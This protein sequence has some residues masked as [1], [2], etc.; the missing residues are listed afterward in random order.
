LWWHKLGGRVA[1]VIGT[2]KQFRA[3]RQRM[4]WLQSEAAD[5]LGVSIY[6]V[7]QWEQGTRSISPMVSRFCDLIE[8]TEKRKMVVIRRR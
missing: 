4:G 8:K 6:A 1:E 2:G 7:R 5:R 3:W